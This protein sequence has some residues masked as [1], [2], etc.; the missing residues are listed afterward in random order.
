MLLS[1]LRRIP[2][3]PAILIISCASLMSACSST[4]QERTENES[5][6]LD[7]FSPYKIDV[8]QGN[9]VSNESLA[10]LKVGMTESQVRFILGAPL[11]ID[12]FHENRW[13]YVFHL[14]KGTGEMTKN[15][16]T[17]FFKNN[18][19]E[20]FENSA[21]PNEADYIAHIM[22]GKPLNNASIET[23]ANE[24]AKAPEDVDA[25]AESPDAETPKTKTEET[26]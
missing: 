12:V 2:L 15:H 22:N 14:K 26:E 25:S 3:L 1:P 10:K 6:W 7:M 17:V 24:S 21:L 23:N 18:V 19:V 16:V 20:Q 5:G 8:Q 9:F 4:P 13:D 11:L